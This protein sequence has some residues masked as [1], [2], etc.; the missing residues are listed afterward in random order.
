MSATP[1]KAKKAPGKTPGAPKT[2]FTAKVR[3]GF[4][5]IIDAAKEALADRA[6]KRAGDR[7]DIEQALQWM[8]E[9]VEQA[10]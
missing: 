10:K 9:N 6:P 3:R 8:E 5:F 1:S 7:A 2:K 4:P